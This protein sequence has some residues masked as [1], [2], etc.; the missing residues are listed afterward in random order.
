MDG[1][2]NSIQIRAFSADGYEIVVCMAGAALA[3]VAKKL[4]EVRAAGYL[5]FAPE[6]AESEHQA[7]ATVM[8]HISELG[9]PVIAAYP[10]W[11]YEGKYGEYKFA[12]IYIDK[13]ED[14]AQ[15]EAQ[16]GLKLDEIP[17]CD[18]E[19]GV[20]R[21]YG[22]VN[23]KE[24]TVKR[25]FD[26][27]KVPDGVFDDGKPRYRY[28]Y[29]IKLAPAPADPNAWIAENVGAWVEK[30]LAK[31]LTEAQLFKALGIT[32]KYRE[33]K[34]TIAQA[35]IAVEAFVNVNAS[36]PPAT[37]KAATA[38][39]LR[40]IDCPIHLLET[41]D[42]VIQ[43]YKTAGT[44][45]ALSRYEIIANW[46]MIAG[47]R[48]CKLKIKDLATGKIGDVSW[49]GSTRTLCDGPKVRAYAS[50][51]D[52]CLPGRNGSKPMWDKQIAE[53]VRV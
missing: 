1:T 50:D 31:D 24:I 21:K 44:G 2:S 47:G 41:G 12:S 46:G 27:V 3:D 7:I 22:K 16:S 9:T 38:A 15:F 37:P 39:P 20:R 25:K 53:P 32:D 36:L 23:P 30:W 19:A 52:V 51:P 28:D 49:T 17:L 45:P 26:M 4:G 33:F 18:A 14:I 43:E 48:Q 42:V 10:H 13:P 29:A 40:Q 6:V 11:Q 34:G 8:R 35:D 5:A